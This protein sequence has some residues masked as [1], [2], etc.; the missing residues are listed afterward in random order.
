MMIPTEAAT[1]TLV[2]NQ[3]SF[4]GQ[5]HPRDFVEITQATP[6]TVPDGKILAIT[7]LGRSVGVPSVDSSTLTIN[8]VQKGIVYMSL[9]LPHV[10]SV[11]PWTQGLAAQAGDLVE[12]PGTGGAAYGY[13]VNE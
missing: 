3:I 10:P 7:A 4:Q 5:V 2:P 6:Y 8:G 13:L 9:N 1:H 12:T 11:L